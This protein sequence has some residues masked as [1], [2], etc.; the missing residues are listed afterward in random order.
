LLFA[1]RV[2]LQAAPARGRAVCNCVGV[3][4]REIQTA[5]AACPA[6]ATPAERLAGLQAQLK[7][8]TQCGSCVPELRRMIAETAGAAVHAAT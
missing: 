1:G 5:L 8:G 3:S 7:C 4:E 6:S 2:P